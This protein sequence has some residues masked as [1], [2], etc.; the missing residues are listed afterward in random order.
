MSML[1]LRRVCPGGVTWT[2]SSALL[3]LVLIGAAKVPSRSVLN[4]RAWLRLGVIWLLL[5]VQE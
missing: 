2:G 3:W 1:A 5:I 4:H